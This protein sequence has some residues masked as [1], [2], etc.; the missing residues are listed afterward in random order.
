MPWTISRAIIWT[1]FSDIESDSRGRQAREEDT[2]C[3]LSLL[4]FAR[5]G[6]TNSNRVAKQVYKRHDKVT[7]WSDSRMTS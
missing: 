4:I 6:S 1:L 3:G 2:H 5:C 7:H